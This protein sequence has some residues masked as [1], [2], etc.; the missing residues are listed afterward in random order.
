MKNKN[1]FLIGIIVSLVGVL[2]IHSKISQQQKEIQFQDTFNDFTS[3]WLK[4]MKIN[5]GDNKSRFT[6][7]KIKS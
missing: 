7:T 1:L 6:T 5:P 4:A 2:L 3:G